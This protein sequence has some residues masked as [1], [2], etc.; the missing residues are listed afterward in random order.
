MRR[1]WLTIDFFSCD[2]LN[3]ND[4]LLPEHLDNLTLS[5]LHRVAILNAEITFILRQA[6]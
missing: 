4:P 1:K 2:A 6:R 3:V 5:P